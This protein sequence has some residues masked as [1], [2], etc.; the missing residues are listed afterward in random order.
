MPFV[1]RIYD[2]AND[3]IW[4]VALATKLDGLENFSKW[5][6]KCMVDESVT[7]VWDKEYMVPRIIERLPAARAKYANA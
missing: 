6:K 2:F 4:P 7:Y 5:A 3:I 1:L